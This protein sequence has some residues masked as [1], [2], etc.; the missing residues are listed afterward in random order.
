[1]EP[2]RHVKIT[3]NKNLYYTLQ[4]WQTFKRC[5]TGQEKLAYEFKEFKDGNESL[6]FLGDSYGCSPIVAIDS[7]DSLRGLL[8]FLLIR[9][10]DIDSENFGNY[11]I[12]QLE[13]A[14]N[15]PEELKFYSEAYYEENKELKFENLDDL[16]D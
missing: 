3:I 6:I 9:P 15:F 1:M 2:L 8:D 12:R 4:T 5:D 7:D 13:F 14:E 11:T 10:H 16:E